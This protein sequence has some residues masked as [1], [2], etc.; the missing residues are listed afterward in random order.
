MSWQQS[1]NG[2]WNPNGSS[3]DSLRAARLNAQRNSALGQQLTLNE[4]LA[5]QNLGLA[6]GPGAGNPGFQNLAAQ[7][8]AQ[9]G[10]FS[11]PQ[12]AQVEARCVGT[13]G[14]AGCL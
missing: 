6:G 1:P 2:N 7:G 12:F 9:Q 11:H 3:E 8:A 14:V 13:F 10:L 4:Q 5:L